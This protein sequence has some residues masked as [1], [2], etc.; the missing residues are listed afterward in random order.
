MKFKMF[1]SAMFELKN[2][3]A[4]LILLGLAFAADSSLVPFFGPDVGLV[5]YP[6]GIVL[7]LIFVIQTLTS[8]KFIESFNRKQKIRHIQDLNYSCLKLANEA[9]RHTNSAY[10]QKLRKVMEDKNDIVNS[11]F[12]G[13]KSY[14]KEKVVEQTLNLVI[15]Y[16]KLLTNFCIRSR[17]LGGIDLSDITNRINSNT[18][19]LSFVNDPH[20]EED[21]KKVIE[22]DEKIIQ[23]LK[24]EKKDLERI[25]AKLDYMESTVNMFKHQVLSSIESE[26]MLEKLES[27]VNEAAALDNVLEERRKSGRIRM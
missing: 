2:I 9:K 21:L 27:A 12:K 5:A 18:R 11:F 20:A 10:Y 6:A 23:R 15:S 17:E 24:D 22:M 16:T 7:Y 13:E 26:E 3:T 14:I 19:K 25:K 4:L 1:V 8:N